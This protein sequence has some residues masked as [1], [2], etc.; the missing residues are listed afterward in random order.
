MLA[1]CIES[2]VRREL[3]MIMVLMAVLQAMVYAIGAVALWGLVPGTIVVILF[4]VTARALSAALF[5]AVMY[6]LAIA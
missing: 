1:I 4:R 6:I 5:L 3:V 2:V